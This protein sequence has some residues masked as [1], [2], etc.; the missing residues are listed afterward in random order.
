MTSDARVFSCGT[1]KYWHNN[2]PYIVNF[3]VYVP[4]NVVLSHSFWEIVYIY[5]TNRI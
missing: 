1:K 4:T 5:K 3:T 2:C